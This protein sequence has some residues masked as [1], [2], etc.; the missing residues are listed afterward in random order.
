MGGV[1]W[2]ALMGC[3]P[4]TS[5]GRKSAAG[6]ALNPATSA[7]TGE[8]TPRDPGMAGGVEPKYGCPP[9]PGRTVNVYV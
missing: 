3:V 7:E 6:R 5:C 4:L 1:P 8:R 9:H 2:L